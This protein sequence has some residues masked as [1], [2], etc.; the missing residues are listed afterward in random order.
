MNMSNSSSK[1]G[2]GCLTVIG[3]VFVVLKLLG[4]APVANWS[5]WWVTSPFWAPAAL[6]VGIALAAIIV[7][8][9]LKAL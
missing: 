6:A 7:I 4:I 8:A 3:I 2:V 5:W 1:N 9:V